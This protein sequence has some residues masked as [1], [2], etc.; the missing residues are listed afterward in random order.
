MGVNSLQIDYRHNKRWE[1]FLLRVSRII[2]YFKIQ[3]SSQVVEDFSRKRTSMPRKTLYHLR[4]E[5]KNRKFRSE[6]FCGISR[7]EILRAGANGANSAINCFDWKFE[8]CSSFALLV[9]QLRWKIASWRGNHGSAFAYVNSQV[10]SQ[11]F[12]SKV[13]LRNQRIKFLE[14]CKNIPKL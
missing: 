9:W 2:K 8:S 4:K 13:C 5:E 14:I 3:Q 1:N 7:N 11:K 6:V 12:R 10:F